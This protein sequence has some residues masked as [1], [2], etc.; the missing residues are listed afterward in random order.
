MIGHGALRLPQEDE[1]RAAAWVIS[2]TRWVIP[3]KRPGYG[4]FARVI[5]GA[6]RWPAD[7]LSPDRWTPTGR[8]VIIGFSSSRTTNSSG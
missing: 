5:N 2:R 8:L 4:A 7:C 6:E 3:P 1:E